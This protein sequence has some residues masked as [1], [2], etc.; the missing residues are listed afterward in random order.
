MPGSERITV[1]LAHINLLMAIGD[2]LICYSEKAIRAHSLSLT[3]F[4]AYQ[5]HTQSKESEKVGSFFP[6]SLSTCVCGIWGGHSWG[7]QSPPPT[8][9]ARRRR[10]RRKCKTAS[11][12]G[13]DAN[14]SL[15]YLAAAAAV[16]VAEEPPSFS[17][18]ITSSSSTR[19]HWASEYINKT[20][21]TRS[22]LVQK[23]LHAH[24]AAAYCFYWPGVDGWVGVIRGGGWG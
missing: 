16:V 14:F 3:P 24:H 22:G 18:Y 4:L 10:R 19:A 7:P 1:S 15:I 23:G 12:C 13:L 11:R 21:I 20:L 6:L 9:G 5:P 8:R 17:V 2:C